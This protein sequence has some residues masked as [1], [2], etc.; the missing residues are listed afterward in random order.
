LSA[1]FVGEKPPELLS[2]HPSDDTRIEKMKKFAEEA[3]KY[4]KKPG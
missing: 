2:T 1:V 4:Y 3:Y